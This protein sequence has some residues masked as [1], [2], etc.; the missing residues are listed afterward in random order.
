MRP[1]AP[2]TIDHLRKR[3]IEG[4]AA[5]DMTDRRCSVHRPLSADRA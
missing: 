1:E 4:E 5:P 2:K 3:A